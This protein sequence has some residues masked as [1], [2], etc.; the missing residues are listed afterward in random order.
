MKIY[1]LPSG[2]EVHR[3]DNNIVIPFQGKRKVLS[4]SPYNGGYRTNLLAVFNH[5]GNP[6]EGCLIEMKGKNYREH[7][8]K[9]IQEIGL[10]LE[11]VTGMETAASMENAAIETETYENM[12]VTAIVTGGIDV[13]GGRVGDPGS[14]VENGDTAPN[15]RLGTINIFLCMNMDLSEGAMARALVTC[16]EAK[17]AALQELMAESR[18]SRGLATGSGTDGTIVIANVESP[19]YLTDAGKHSKLGELIGTA[20]KKAVKQALFLQ[21]GLG[22]KKQHSAVRRLSRFGISEAGIYHAYRKMAEE[23]SSGRCLISRTDFQELLEDICAEGRMVADASFLA[24][25]MDQM[26]WGL[27]NVAEVLEASERILKDMGMEK[28]LSA[29]SIRDPEEAVAVIREAFVETVIGIVEKK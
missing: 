18:Y 14:W 3:F 13:N 23:A 26:D 27:L 22:P 9:T 20:V 5:D 11:T 25:G 29:Q 12:A 7:M 6:G 2:D 21:T 17:T 4:T 28:I 8:I 10:E 19:C 24:H 15:Y 16:T 1:T